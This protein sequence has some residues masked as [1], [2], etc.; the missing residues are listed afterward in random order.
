MKL[1][2]AGLAFAVLAL[3]MLAMPASADDFINVYENP[4]EISVTPGLPFMALG[5]ILLC[6]P[7]YTCPTSVHGAIDPNDPMWSDLVRFANVP[8]LGG[9]VVILY[10]EAMIPDFIYGPGDITLMIADG[11][12]LPGDFMGDNSGLVIPETFP[13]TEYAVYHIYSD[14]Y[15]TVPEPGTMLLVGAGLLGLANSLRKRPSH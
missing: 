6:E 15:E 14:E 4:N 11:F 5:D 7:G 3:L 10:S 2:Y 8:E 12:A 13:Y 9:Y 1:R